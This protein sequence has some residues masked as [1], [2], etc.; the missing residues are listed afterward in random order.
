MALI[1][2]FVLFMGHPTYALTVIIFSMLV[3]SGVGSFW[4]RRWITS[5]GFLANRAALESSC[6]SIVMAFVTTPVTQALVGLA[7]SVK[8]LITVV[9][10]APLA[11]LMGMPFPAGLALIEKIHQESVRWAWALNA[12]SSVLGSASAIFIAIYAGLKATMIAGG[13]CYL[14]ALAA[15]RSAKR[16]PGALMQKD[17]CAAPCSSGAIPSGM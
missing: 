16:R 15:R 12:S 9:G 11:F 6:W 13:V 3:S 10:I 17:Q 4:S 5:P 14:L 2:K 1:Q 7:L 8:I